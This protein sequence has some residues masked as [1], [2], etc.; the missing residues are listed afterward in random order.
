MS[1]HLL[2]RFGKFY[3]AGAVLFR[4]GEPGFEMFAIH[5]GRV[6][7]TKRMKERDAV[8]ATLGPGDFFGEM[9]ILNNRPRSATAVIALDAWLL[10]IDA[11]TFEAMIR[12]RAEIAVRMI[13]TL[14]ARLEQAN[15]QIELLLLKDTNHRVVLC[16][17][18]LA[19]RTGTKISDGASVFIPVTLSSLAGRVALSEAEVADV[20]ARLG[21]A[22]LIRGA[23]EAGFEE[24]GYVIPEVGRLV[25]FLEFLELKDRF[26]AE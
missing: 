11:R 15:Q 20:L 4:E 17:R 21:E 6:Q 2:E 1:D 7:L 5:S 9:A 23:V 19:E 14:A 26:S 8:L 12:A 3:P 10:V 22:R 24:E 13:K 18:N 16:L 25:D